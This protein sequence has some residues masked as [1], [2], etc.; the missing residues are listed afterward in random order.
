MA[1][2]KSNFA[3]I[4]PAKEEIFSLAVA[5]TR[6]AGHQPS[7]AI[8]H[9][10]V[11]VGID[12]NGQLIRLPTHRIGGRYFTSQRA[13]DWLIAMQ[14]RPAAA[15]SSAIRSRPRKRDLA[16]SSTSESGV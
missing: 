7:R 6:V 5:R 16:A 12:V 3:P 8:I 14:N 4:D 9:K 2:L 15:A 1:K 11:H 13:I 10:W